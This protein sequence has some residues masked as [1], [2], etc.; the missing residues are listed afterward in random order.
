MD[1][2]LKK[3]HLAYI[4][5]NFD[6]N[7]VFHGIHSSNELTLPTVHRKSHPITV[8]TLPD[9]SFPIIHNVTYLTWKLLSFCD[10]RSLSNFLQ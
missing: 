5:A 1:H 7:F 10:I 8:S 4:T 9:S 2:F 6:I 3:A